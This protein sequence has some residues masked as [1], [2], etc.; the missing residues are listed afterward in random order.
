MQNKK[1]IIME[2]LFTALL[3]PIIKESLREA[4]NEMDAE[5]KEQEPRFITRAEVAEMLGV[6]LVTVHSYVNRGLLEC[7]KIGHKTLFSEADVLKAIQG[8]K[9]YKFKHT[10]D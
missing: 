9:V 4:L 6:S 10:E 8:K 3:K 7:K 2:E 1:S 5:R